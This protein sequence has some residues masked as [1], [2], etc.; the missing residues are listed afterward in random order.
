VK[1]NLAAKQTVERSV[2]SF[3]STGWSRGCVSSGRMT[4][5]I[6]DGR[7]VALMLCLS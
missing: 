6:S 5:K 4:G 2:P 1:P 3:T 7:S